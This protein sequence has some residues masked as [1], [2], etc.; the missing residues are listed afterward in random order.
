MDTKK[1]QCDLVTEFIG[2]N[3][4]VCAMSYDQASQL[5]KLETDASLCTLC[6]SFPPQKR[7]KNVILGHSCSDIIDFWPGA[8]QPLPPPGHLLML[9]QDYGTEGLWYQIR[10]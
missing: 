8:Q 6:M 1:S 5:T 2:E 7:L 9:G 10:E 4:E 3:L